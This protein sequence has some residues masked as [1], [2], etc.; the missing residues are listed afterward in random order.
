[1]MYRVHLVLECDR[2]LVCKGMHIYLYRLNT[3]TIYFIRISY[4]T[5]TMLKTLYV[6]IFSEV[7]VR[8]L[9]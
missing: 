5:S 9:R 1:M 2:P 4:D 8:Y 3:Q 7:E 6:H